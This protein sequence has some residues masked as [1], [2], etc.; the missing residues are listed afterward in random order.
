MLDI[1]KDLF[2]SSAVR[3][4]PAAAA[5]RTAVQA[6]PQV[7]QPIPQGSTSAPVNMGD[8]PAQKDVPEMTNYPTHRDN[9]QMNTPSESLAG[10]EGL[11]IPQA[12]GR[13]I[14]GMVDL[15]QDASG[16]L[17]NTVT[18]SAGEIADGVGAV[19]EG[20]S[21][22]IAHSAGEVA[23]TA[24]E[25][26][27]A[28]SDSTVANPAV[29]AA[30]LEADA[31]SK[32]YGEGMV[33]YS[34]ELAKL[35]K[36]DSGVDKVI[37]AAGE[38]DPIEL[39]NVLTP[40]VKTKVQLAADAVAKAKGDGHSMK[41][42]MKG[43]T[44]FLGD[45]FNDPAIK[46]ALIYYTGSRLMG[47]S[48]SGSGMAAGQVL[49]QG[50]KTQD[51]MGIKTADRNAKAAAD[52]AKASTL[53][54]SKTVTKFDPRTKQTVDVYQAPNGDTQIVGTGKTY[55]AQTTGFVDYKK[56][57]HKTFEDMDNEL[58]AGTD[59]MIAS[60]LANIQKGSGDDGD[61]QY[62]TRGANRVDE[63][64][65]D[66]NAQR[67]L[68]LMT[69]RSMKAAG[70]DY[71]T[72]EFQS[73]YKATIQTYMRDVANG[74]YE[75]GDQPAMADMVGMMTANWLKTDLKGE[76]SV[77]EFILGE[78]T[79]DGSNQYTKNFVLPQ[80]DA[81]KLHKQ[82]TLISN[83]LIDQAI[84][85]GH[86]PAKANALINKSKTLNKMGNIFKNEVM[87]DPVAKKFW[88]DKAK[89][90][91]T[92][93]FNVWLNSAKLGEEAKYMGVSNPEIRKLLSTI[94]VKDFEPKTK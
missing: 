46:R 54:L 70:I 90:R 88:M 19:V 48:G 41:D 59:A 94:Y 67:E 2:G 92:N 30:K 39:D 65:A 69:T 7:A 63:L 3:T 40:E 91:G 74:K 34:Q 49:L 89:G 25:F 4:G 58:I 35:A 77:P 16:Y 18:N 50:W 68:L 13:N 86:S 38:I 27:N 51:A 64:F 6:V 11:S 60:T 29:L 57:H 93:S 28:F 15:A 83:Q 12:I 82:S 56:G 72:P 43:A 66:G 17:V 9:Y 78:K 61:T 45:L 1:L 24:S 14:G 20:G 62:T 8:F 5:A 21:K 37:S 55:A 10:Y 84:A 80:A 71:G 36:A 75:N 26:A 87:S 23:E 85:N 76:G 44:G 22:Q 73:A 31:D 42:A 79:W 33:K 52:N 32:A 53:D 81:L 47:Y